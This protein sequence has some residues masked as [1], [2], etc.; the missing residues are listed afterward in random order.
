MKQQHTLIYF[1]S[2]LACMLLFCISVSAQNDSIPK[3][4][5]D[6]IKIK[7][8]YGLRV[9]ADIGRLIRSSLDDD[10]SGFEL[11]ADYRIKKRLYIAGEIGF[12]E[13]NT[14]T[15][16]LDV[17]S[18]GSY[19]KG[20]IDYNL[21]ENWLDMDNMIYTGF[22]IGASTF[23]HDI[24]SFTTYSTNQYWAPQFSSNE[25][26]EFSDLTAFWAELLLGLKAELF[27]NLYIGLNV[28]LKILA[29]QDQPK[30]FENIYIP[31]FNKTFDGSSIGVGY[32]YFISYRIPLYK[33]AAK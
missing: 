13:K 32:S 6:S 5:N 9:G 22:R 28:Q 21:Y 15:D 25:K 1:I 17:T 11:M 10:Y 3:T 12:E 4:P 30:N 2:S 14:I 18:K 24:N 19:I 23:S 29:S 7:L 27:N 8:K 26:Q 20:G 16:F 31:G 33:R